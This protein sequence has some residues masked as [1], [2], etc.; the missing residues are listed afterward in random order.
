MNAPAYGYSWHHGSVEVEKVTNKDTIDRLPDGR[1]IAV[2]DNGNFIHGPL[3]SIADAREC[4][5][6][7]CDCWKERVK[8]DQAAARHLLMKGSK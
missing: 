8:A 1:F 7:R 3:V 4:C 2:L 5:K 6:S